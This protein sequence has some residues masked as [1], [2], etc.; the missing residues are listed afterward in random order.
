M[1]KLQYLAR[2]LSRTKR[3][4]YEN[5][6]VNAIWNR[7]ADP[8]IQPVSQQYIGKPDNNGYFI[9]LY[10]PQ[11]NI[12]IECDEPFH[13]RTRTHDK[14]REV[15]LMDILRRIDPDSGYEALHIDVSHGFDSTEKQIDHAV[16]VLRSRIEELRRTHRLEEWR[17][18]LTP[19][20]YFAHRETVRV[21][22]SVGFP[23]ISETCNVLFDAGYE[24]D[25]RR[26]GFTPRGPFSNRFRG[27]YGVWFPKLSV[28]GSDAA[29]WIN[30]V[31]IDGT[32]LYEGNEDG[33]EGLSG[34]ENGE[35]V[36]FAKTRDPVLHT[37]EY[38]FLGVFQLDGFQCIDGR[39]Y[40]RYVRTAEEFPL[41]RRMPSAEPDDRMRTLVVKILTLI[42]TKTEVDEQ[43][44][45]DTISELCRSSGWEMD[46][47]HA[48]EVAYGRAVFDA[49]DLEK[50]IGRINEIGLLG[51]GIYSQWRYLTHWQFGGESFYDENHRPWFAMAFHRLYEL[52][53]G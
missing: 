17:I 40:R 13:L 4:D 26:C 14:A 38:R 9:D 24:H 3:K 32:E 16:A 52:I 49:K 47:G 48:F 31:S 5:Y 46:C 1:D 37:N 41:L 50:V 36:V 6:V 10:F 25:L 53:A 30:L 11:L 8:R 43:Q 44:L 23:T 19:A 18:G 42:E 34:S 12:G 33:I 7:L 35:R 15:E 20:E 45:V 2:T 39:N 27:R 51:S 21:A 28:E 22:D 29:G